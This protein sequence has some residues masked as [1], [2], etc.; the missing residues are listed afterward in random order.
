MHSQHHAREDGVERDKD[1]T[2]GVD[3]LIE[4]I[5]EISDISRIDGMTGV[6]REDT[7]D[8]NVEVNIDHIAIKDRINIQEEEGDMN[9][10]LKTQNSYNPGLMTVL[11][12]R[13][14]SQMMQQMSIM[15][16]RERK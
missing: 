9:L 8:M 16:G 10:V 4:S 7:T 13:R 6:V 14:K 3:P 11:K 15:R 12:N 1:Q 5:I 2:K